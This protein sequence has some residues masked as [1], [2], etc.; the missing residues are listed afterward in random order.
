MIVDAVW[1]VLSGIL[2][3]LVSALPTATVDTST[4]PGHELAHRIAAFDQLIPI[5]GPITLVV[6]MLGALAA[7]FA[8]RVIVW[9]WRL[10]PMT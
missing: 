6:G 10:L 5:A 8:F 2:G 1:T 9:V 4:W 3:P 7:V